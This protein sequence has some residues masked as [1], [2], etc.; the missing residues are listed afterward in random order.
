MIHVGTGFKGFVHRSNQQKNIPLKTKRK[1]SIRGRNE[2][3]FVLPEK[4]ETVHFL[5][6]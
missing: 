6:S 4:K 1:E 5:I 3:Y 2:R